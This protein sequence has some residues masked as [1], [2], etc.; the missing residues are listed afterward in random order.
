MGDAHLASFAE[1]LHLVTSKL[2]LNSR[3]VVS[4]VILALNITVAAINVVLLS[5]LQVL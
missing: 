4:L 1:V 5:L 2:L 3:Q